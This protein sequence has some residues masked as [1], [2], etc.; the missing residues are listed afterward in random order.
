[1]RCPLRAASTAGHRARVTG[2]LVEIASPHH[3]L[4]T[5]GPERIWVEIAAVEDSGQTAAVVR[6][7]GNPAALL[8]IANRT[9]RAAATSCSAPAEH[10][11][12]YPGDPACLAGAGLPRQA[13]TPKDLRLPRAAGHYLSR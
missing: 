2:R 13:G 4:G 3:L 1:M 11:S 5:S 12:R 9:S 10:T 6:V 7:D 8:A